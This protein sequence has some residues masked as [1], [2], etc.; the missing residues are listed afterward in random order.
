MYMVASGQQDFVCAWLKGP[1]ERVRQLAFIR[2]VTGYLPTLCGPVPHRLKLRAGCPASADEWGDTD[3]IFHGERAAVC[4]ILICDLPC[5]VYHPCII[6]PETSF[7]PP[8]DHHPREALS[9]SGLRYE[10]PSSVGT[11]VW[12][13]ACS[14]APWKSDGG[15]EALRCFEADFW[16]WDKKQC[17]ASNCQSSTSCCLCEVVCLGPCLGGR[18]H[19]LGKQ[20]VWDARRWRSCGQCGWGEMVAAQLH[21]A[22]A[23]THAGREHCCILFGAV[24]CVVNMRRA[25][26]QEHC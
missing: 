10:P 1:A 19:E 7:V 12:C 24:C 25:L 4:L 11:A 17:A 23:P 5:L 18:H 8:G 2:S 3:V 6:V 22:Q 15:Q 14:T 13:V 16:D 21:N 26:L 20:H 9:H